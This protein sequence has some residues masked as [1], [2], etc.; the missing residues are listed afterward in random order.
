MSFPLP[1]PAALQ[2]INDAE[3]LEGSV[4]VSEGGCAFAV[5]AETAGRVGVGAASWGWVPIGGFLA[6]PS[7]CPEG[8]DGR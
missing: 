6:A 3:K 4:N 1:L 8:S 2:P 7:H 5:G